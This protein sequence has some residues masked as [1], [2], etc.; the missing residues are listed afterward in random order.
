MKF[1]SK[2]VQ[3]IIQALM[4]EVLDLQQIMLAAKEGHYPSKAFANET[5]S[6]LIT[7]GIG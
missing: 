5:K 7:E 2:T 6:Q 4:L 3:T 1:K